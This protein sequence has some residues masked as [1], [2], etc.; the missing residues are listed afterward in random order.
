[1]L[2]EELNH[3]HN[4]QAHPESLIRIRKPSS[5]VP[6]VVDSL[7]LNYGAFPAKKAFTPSYIMV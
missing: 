7:P 4:H 1:V 5:P 2:P 6:L 3:P